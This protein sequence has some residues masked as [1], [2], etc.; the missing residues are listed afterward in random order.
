MLGLSSHTINNVSFVDFKQNQMS[1]DY[2][3]IFEHYTI[4]FIKVLLIANMIK[5]D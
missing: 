5:H 2:V 1:F 3:P 4:L